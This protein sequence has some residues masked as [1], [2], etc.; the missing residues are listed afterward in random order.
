MG[1]KETQKV[2]LKAGRM[3]VEKAEEKVVNLVVRKVYL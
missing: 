1:S 3:V 2:E